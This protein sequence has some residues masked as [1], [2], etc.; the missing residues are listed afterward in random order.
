MRKLMITKGFLE[1]KIGLQNCKSKGFFPAWHALEENRVGTGADTSEDVDEGDEVG[2]QRHAVK[3]VIENLGLKHPIIFDVYNVFQYYHSNNLPSFNVSML[4]D[5]CGYFEIPYKSRD[6][7][8]D[9][10]A[11]VSELVKDV[12][13]AKDNFIRKILSAWYL[14]Q[15]Q[16][17]QYQFI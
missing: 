15:C 1:G 9:L 3:E 14:V 2:E 17:L 8:R 5:M 6:P 10:F 13:A 11:K 12:S 4:K 16:I 7:K